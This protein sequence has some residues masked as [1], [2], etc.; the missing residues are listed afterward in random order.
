[1]SGQ[2]PD[3]P[4]ANAEARLAH[5]LDTELDFVWRLLRRLGVTVGRVDDE[6]QRVFLILASKLDQVELGS[7]RSFLVSTAVRVAANA[8]RS[9]AGLREDPFDE[10]VSAM[11]SPVPSQEE[12]LDHKRRRELLD[13]ILDQLGAEQRT[14]FVLSELERMSRE[15]IARHL[16]WPLGTVASRLRLARQHFYRL[17]A[18]AHARLCSGHERSEP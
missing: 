10:A 13:R 7:E 1:M 8:R 5:L 15:Q 2:Q 18:R 11:A 6:S 4:C 14:V 9:Q 3:S 17:V 16:G 12:L